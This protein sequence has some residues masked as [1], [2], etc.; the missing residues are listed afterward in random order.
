MNQ[1]IYKVAQFKLH[2]SQRWTSEKCVVLQQIYSKN[3]SS[4][5]M[6]FVEMLGI[7]PRA[8]EVSSKNINRGSTKY[9]Y[10]IYNMN[11]SSYPFHEAKHIQYGGR[12]CLL[13]SGIAA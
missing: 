5:N 8:K 3:Y 9:L 1:Y 11:Y 7:F 2:I 12:H 4:E 10:R 6:T 13:P